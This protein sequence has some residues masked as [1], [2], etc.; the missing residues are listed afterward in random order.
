MGFKPAPSR[1]LRRPL[2]AALR[3]TFDALL[4]TRSAFS[5]NVPRAA[6]L[7]FPHRVRMARLGTSKSTSGT[8]IIEPA[9]A[10]LLPKFVREGAEG[11]R[12]SEAGHWMDWDDLRFV[13]AVARAGSA[14]RAARALDVNQT[15][16]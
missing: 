5:Q 2:V 8:R 4:P 11:S 13:L 3:H 9:S 10:P 1:L 7:K 14:H 16:V 15:T 6:D 12:T